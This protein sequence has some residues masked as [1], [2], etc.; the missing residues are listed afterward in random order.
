[1]I[2]IFNKNNMNIKFRIVSPETYY[3]WSYIEIYNTDYSDPN[4]GKP[5]VGDLFLFEG[6]RI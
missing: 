4:T 3:H 6:I 2:S 5:T 1:M